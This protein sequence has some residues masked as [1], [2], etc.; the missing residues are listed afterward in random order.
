GRFPHLDV[1]LAGEWTRDVED[2]IARLISVLVLLGRCELS[3]VEVHLPPG[4]LPNKE[5]RLALKAAARR[6]RGTA[7]MMGDEPLSP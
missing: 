4:L 7:V 3:S 2:S 1:H 5:H 6:L